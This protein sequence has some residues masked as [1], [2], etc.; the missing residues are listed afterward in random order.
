M[1]RSTLRNSEAPRTLGSLFVLGL[2]AVG[3]ASGCGFGGGGVSP[4]RTSFN[5]GVYHYSA[6]NLDEAI[7]EYRLALDENAADRHARFNL[8]VALEAKG[9]ELR[10]DGNAGA[11]E[12]LERQAEAEYRQLV[13]ENPKLLRAIVNLAAC[14][15]DRG[16]REQAT[17]RLE[18]AIEQFPSAALPCI[19]LAAHQFKELRARAAESP[20]REAYESILAR[21]DEGLERDPASIKGNMLRGGVHAELAR[22][23]RSSPS[24]TSALGV[25]AATH[26]AAARESYQKA[27][28]REPSDIAT[29]LA[30]GRLEKDEKSWAVAASYFERVTYID[31][32]HLEARLALSEVLAGTGDFEGATYNL[33]RAR[34]LDRR[35]SPRLSPEE[36]RKRLLAL[37]EILAAE[38]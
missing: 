34:A 3:L 2:I 6:G 10:R 24:E 7:A 22:Q 5:K 11:A 33:W 9:R 14:E 16:D 15:Y 23:A 28:L 31:P 1:R 12:K 21:L 38:E 18:E 13:D 37:Y 27:L 30:L 19:A 35:P 26:V 17:R 8:A 20:S 32:D 29:L 36:Y 25:D 4:V